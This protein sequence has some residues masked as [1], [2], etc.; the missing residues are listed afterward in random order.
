MRIAKVTTPEGRPQMLN[1]PS[2]VAKFDVEDAED[3]ARLL[4]VATTGRQC[5][6]AGYVGKKLK[7]KGWLDAATQNLIGSA[8]PPTHL[9]RRGFVQVYSYECD[10]DSRYSP[11]IGGGDEVEAEQMF[12][13][14]AAK[15]VWR[16]VVETGTV[17]SVLE[18]PVLVAIGPNAASLALHG[19]FL[20]ALVTATGVAIEGAVQVF[21]PISGMCVIA[22]KGAKREELQEFAWRV[23][24]EKV[25]KYY[26][27]IAG[28][29]L[30]YWDV[31][32][33]PV[34]GMGRVIIEK[35]GPK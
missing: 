26:P 34:D 30:Q 16:V 25:A 22:P 1:L 20:R 3:A 17:G 2:L 8:A 28:E 10:H 9:D 27:Q 21:A 7:T 4:R 23:F 14:D 6:C 32:S 31:V 33:L 18:R 5:D 15:H 29:E 35:K 12:L 24:S 11:E 19:G 13:R